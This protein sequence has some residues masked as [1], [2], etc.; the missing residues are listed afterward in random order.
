MI[1]IVNA[2]NDDHADNCEVDKDQGEGASGDTVNG[3][4]VASNKP[5]LLIGGGRIRIRL[6]CQTPEDWAKDINNVMT[7]LRNDGIDNTED[8]SRE[9]FDLLQDDRDFDLTGS[10]FFEDHLLRLDR[11]IF[12]L[13]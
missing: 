3:L 2:D 9:A 13:L 1:V 11:C 12:D 10:L 5:V 8:D 6:Q 7:W 4:T